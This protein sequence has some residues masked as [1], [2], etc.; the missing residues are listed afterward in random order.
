[1]AI[2]KPTLQIQSFPSDYSVVADR[3]PLSFNLDLSTTV[4][5]TT[6]GV[7]HGRKSVS[8]AEAGN[9]TDYLFDGSVL[10]TADGGVAGTDGCFLYLKNMTAA[11][12]TGDIMIG[13]E[14]DDSDLSDAANLGV[15]EAAARLFTLKP[16]EF[17][18]FP[19]DGTMDISVDATADNTILEW[20]KFDR[21]TTTSGYIGG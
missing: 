13:I 1:M 21:T 8:I 17:A 16:Q 18:F 12:G 15:A 10:N 5:V 7:N 6:V 11:G 20:W 9:T 19:Y 2:I 3:G 14:P 4:D